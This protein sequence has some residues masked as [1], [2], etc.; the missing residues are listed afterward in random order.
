MRRIPMIF[1]GQASQS[2]GMA[3]DLMDGNGAA[4]D[5]LG[6][7]DNLRLQKPFDVTNFKKIVDK[8][9]ERARQETTS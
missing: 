6:K 7:V 2:V 9:I 8:S 3:A 1:P 4:A 5:Y